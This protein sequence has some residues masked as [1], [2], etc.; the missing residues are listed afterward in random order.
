MHFLGGKQLRVRCGMG[1]WAACADSTVLDKWKA[2][3][4]RRTDGNAKPSLNLRTGVAGLACFL[5]LLCKQGVHQIG[6]RQHPVQLVLNF[7]S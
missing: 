4:E 1:F 2:P 5:S 7:P 6:N 3:D